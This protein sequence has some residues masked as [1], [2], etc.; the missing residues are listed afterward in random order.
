VILLLLLGAGA[1]PRGTCLMEV[2]EPEAGDAASH[3]CC[4]PGLTAQLPACCHAGSASST[5]A[6]PEAKG[7]TAAPVVSIAA[8]LVPPATCPLACAASLASARVV[9]HSPPLSILRI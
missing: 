8:V 9:A 7:R 1:L 5:P 3:G 6:A 4:G 2:P